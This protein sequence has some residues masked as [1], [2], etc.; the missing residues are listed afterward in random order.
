[1]NC[2]GKTALQKEDLAGQGKD[3]EVHCILEN[4]LSIDRFDT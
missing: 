4:V 3:A 2:Q 1:M